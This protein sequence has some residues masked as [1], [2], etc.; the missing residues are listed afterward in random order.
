M[1]S[2]IKAAFA[3]EDRTLLIPYLTAGWPAPADTVPLLHALEEGGADLIEIGV[4]F[5]DPSADG[6]VIQR[7]NEQAL[8]AG[9]KLR[10]CVG[11]CRRLP[12]RRRATAGRADGLRQLLLPLRV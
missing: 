1:T 6:T 8:A 9:G 2:R 3:A 10:R 4:P 7:A 11:R 12:R 5:S